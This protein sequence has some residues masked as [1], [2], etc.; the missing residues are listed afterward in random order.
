VVT[1]QNILLSA[2][3]ILAQIEIQ[4]AT[5]SVQLIEALG[6]GWDSSRLP[7]PKQVSAKPDKADTA[8]QQ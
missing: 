8:L 7:T 1:Q 5:A 2:Q 4:R 6:G 3:Q